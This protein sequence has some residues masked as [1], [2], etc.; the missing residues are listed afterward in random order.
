MAKFDK[1]V[2]LAE[3]TD[4]VKEAIESG[5]ISQ[6]DINN[7]DVDRL[8]GFLQYSLSD[9]LV[10]RK[11][12]I[13]VLRDFNYDERYSWESLEEQIGGKIKSL[14]DVAL[15]NLWKFLEASG[16]LTFA[17]YVEGV[18]PEATKPGKVVDYTEDEFDED[19]FELAGEISDE[20]N[21][22]EDYE[23]EFDNEYNSYDEEDLEKLSSED[24]IEENDVEESFEYD[25]YCKFDFED[26]DEDYKYNEIVRRRNASQRRN[27]KR[28]R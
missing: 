1:D 26:E 17:Y 10:D 19:D 15:A 21:E 6:E 27:F 3:M 9:Y 20:E 16:L 25:D 8:T 11:N 2:F 18:K 5:L 28:S 4:K 22:F 13:D 12:A 14:F 7:N 24:E 23:E